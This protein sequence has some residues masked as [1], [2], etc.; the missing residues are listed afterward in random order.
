MIILRNK[1]FSLFNIF[2]K[3]ENTSADSSYSDSFDEPTTYLKLCRKYPKLKDLEVFIKNKDT[4]HSIAGDL[5][6][7]RIIVDYEQFSPA[8]DDEREDFPS[9]KNWTIKCREKLRSDS[10]I[11]CVGDLFYNK[12]DNSFYDVNLY[13]AWK[14]KVQKTTVQEYKKQLVKELEDLAGDP[15][16]EN[17]DDSVE[18][19]KKNII[20]RLKKILRV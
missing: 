7:Y 8:F 19:L 16:L 4:L 6:D 20:P 3:K 1:E 13:A 9:F 17:P 11:P 12:D 10:W 2:K 18:Y 15:F 5:D 14:P